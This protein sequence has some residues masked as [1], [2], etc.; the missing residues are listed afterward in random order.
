MP[1]GAKSLA[2]ASGTQYIAP[3]TPTLWDARAR[4]VDIASPIGRLAAP[5]YCSK[6]P[7][8]PL[9]PLWGPLFCLK[10]KGAFRCPSLCPKGAL[11]HIL[12]PKG[13]R[14]QLPPPSGYIKC[15]VAPLG[16]LRAYIA[17]APKGQ[18]HQPSGSKARCNERQY[19]DGGA[20][21]IS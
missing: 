1:E 11:W 12:R 15:Y 10:A 21:N 17:L 13:L 16:P 9:G 14:N 8:C 19:I 2:P 18:R 5:L 6:G 3:L 4:R 7:R 20:G